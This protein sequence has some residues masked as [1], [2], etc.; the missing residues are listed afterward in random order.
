MI[1][2]DYASNH[3]KDCNQMFN[4]EMNYVHNTRCHMVGMYV[5]YQCNAIPG[6]FH[7]TWSSDRFQSLREQLYIRSREE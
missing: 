5:L 3:E 7:Q 4:L 2:M 1:K 6:I